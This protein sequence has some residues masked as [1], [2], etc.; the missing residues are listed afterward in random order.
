[1]R[2][3]IRV[4]SPDYLPAEEWTVFV[5]PENTQILKAFK[6]FG[7]WYSALSQAIALAAGEYTAIIEVF[8][9]LVSGYDGNQKVWAEQL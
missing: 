5:S 4:L 1:V 9:D 6:G 7:A 3:E 8:P 2:P